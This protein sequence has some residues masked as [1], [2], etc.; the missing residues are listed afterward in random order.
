M[1]LWT[2]CYY[3]HD[4]SLAR[5]IPVYCVCYSFPFFVFECLP[6]VCFIFTSYDCH[7]DVLFLSRSSLNEAFKSFII[8]EATKIRGI[9]WYFRNNL[10]SWNRAVKISRNIRVIIPWKIM[11]HFTIAKEKRFSTQLSLSKYFIQKIPAPDQVVTYI[12]HTFTTSTSR[13]PPRCVRVWAPLKL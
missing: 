12:A 4:N 3:S 9:L 10:L 13:P 2:A 8:S 7:A 6:T 11:A 5:S 1:S